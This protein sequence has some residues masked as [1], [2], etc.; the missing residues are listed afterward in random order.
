[1]GLSGIV[2]RD[3]TI[4]VV[5]TGAI[6]RAL[7][8]IAKGFGMRVLAYDLYPNHSLD[9]EYVDLDTLFRNSDVI[10][11]HCPLTKETY[12]LLDEEAL[13][14]ILSKPKNA[15]IKQY[16]KLFELDGVELEFEPEALTAIATKAIERNTGARGL[17]AIM[18]SVV[19][20]LMYTVPSDNKIEK[21]IITKEAV[22]KTAEPT[23]IYSDKPVNRRN[24]G[25]KHSSKNNG[26]IA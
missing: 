2:L 6:G 1:M 20:D 18:E 25:K 17:R 7:I 13:V 21:C 15:I 16:K 22:E 4:G 23:I 26:E 19:M 24:I 3:K 10:S 5:G 9:V 14:E 8:N 12:H 11:L